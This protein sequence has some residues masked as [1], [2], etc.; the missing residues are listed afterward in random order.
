[1]DVLHKIVCYKYELHQKTNLLFGGKV[2]QPPKLTNYN[3]KFLKCCYRKDF[4]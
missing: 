4:T 3:D 2:I 1:M